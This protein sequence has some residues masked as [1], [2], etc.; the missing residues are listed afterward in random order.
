VLGSYTVAEIVLL[1]KTVHSG[2]H[3]ADQHIKGFSCG[4]LQGDRQMLFAIAFLFI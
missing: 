2:Q 1:V 3:V 4:A